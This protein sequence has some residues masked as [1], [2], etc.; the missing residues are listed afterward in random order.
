[1]V[2]TLTCQKPAN[3]LSVQ[4]ALVSTFF[5]MFIV[6]GMYNFGS[7]QKSDSQKENNQTAMIDILMGKK[8]ETSEK[9]EVLV[10]F[11]IIALI[12]FPH[13]FDSCNQQTRYS[14]SFLVSPKGGLI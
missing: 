1:M 9:L 14:L 4:M 12:H 8:E 7:A 13:G 10:V 5:L 3:S 6:L 11:E 2:N